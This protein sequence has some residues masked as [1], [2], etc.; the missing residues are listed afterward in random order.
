M[1]HFRY[2]SPRTGYLKTNC[3][4]YTFF[5]EIKDMLTYSA[6]SLHLH[7]LSYSLIILGCIITLI[8]Y[9]RMFP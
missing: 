1:L 8:S 6:V 5:P 9:V 2:S 7:L 3:N 4:I